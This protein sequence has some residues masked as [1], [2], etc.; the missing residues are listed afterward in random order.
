[1]TV[2][3]KYVEWN[4]ILLQKEKYS[5]LEYEIKNYNIYISLKKV[6]MKKIITIKIVQILLF[7]NIFY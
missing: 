1:M 7:P 2:N 4:I 3:C 5:D 6:K